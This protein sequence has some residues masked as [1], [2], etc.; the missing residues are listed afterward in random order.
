MCLP[1]NPVLAPVRRHGRNRKSRGLSPRLVY[2]PRM[3][4]ACIMARK[5]DTCLSF[6]W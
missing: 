6:A 3:A 1:I 5:L 4:R 2:Q